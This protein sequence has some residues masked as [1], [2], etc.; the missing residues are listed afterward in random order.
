MLACARTSDAAVPSGYAGRR[1]LPRQQSALPMTDPRL[2]TAE[3]RPFRVTHRSVVAL[4]LPMTLAFLTTPLVG[5]TDTVVIGRLGEPALLGGIAIAAI[6]F[7]LVSATFGFLRMGTGGLTAQAFGAGDRLAERLVLVRA[8][9]LAVV[10]GILV[11]LVERPLLALFLPAMRASAGVEAAVRAYVAIRILS[12]PFAF[13]NFAVLG[14]IVGLGRAGLG[15]ALQVFLNGVNIGLAVWLALGLGR[16]LAGVAWA[17]VAAEASAA[18]AGLAVVLVLGRGAPWPPLRAVFDRAGLARLLGVNRDIMIRSAVLMTAFVFFTAQGAR[19]GDVVLAAN[20][21]LMNFFMLGAL[22]LD[23]FA[24]AAEQL[25]GRAIGA[26]WRPAFEAAV[27]L[28]LVWGVVLGAL[29]TLVL[30]AA[31]PAIVDLASTA[32]A[33]RAEARLYLPWMAA[34]PVAA[35][36][37]FVLDGVYIG[38]TWTRTMRNMMLVSLAGYFLVYALL[39]PRLGNHGLWIALLAFLALRGITLGLGLKRRLDGTFAAIAA[40]GPAQAASGSFAAQA[41]ASQPTAAASE[42]RRR[43]SSA[44]ASPSSTAGTTAG[45]A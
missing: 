42:G 34:A 26:R 12:M 10:L 9:G 5:L 35:A 36:A 20:A 41:A 39:E 29:A 15:L 44:A 37:A 17:T 40:A 27:R 8:L 28:S 21:V 32:P 4:A 30:A 24:A 18:A 16:G 22:F 13:V 19:S 43:C 3:P 31:G 2:A 33:V 38:A 25:A 7:D 45:P 23:G 14:W 6:L 11:V 1:P